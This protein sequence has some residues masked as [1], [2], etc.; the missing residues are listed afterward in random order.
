MRQR[1]SSD[2]STFVFG[3]EKKFE[4]TGN[5]G[6]VSIYKRDLLAGST[7]LDW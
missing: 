2:G 1:F 3:A 5:E 4:G 6:S 7:H